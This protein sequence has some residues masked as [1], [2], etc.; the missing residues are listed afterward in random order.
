VRLKIEL[1]SDKTKRLP[2]NYHYQ[3]SSAIYLLLKFSSSEFSDFLHNIGYKL[4]GKPYKLFT[5][6]LK[7]EKYSTSN[8]EIILESPNI[9]LTVSSPKID[10][11]IK[12]FVIGSFERTFFYI[13][14]GGDEH[15][16][17]IK[18]MEL[19][20]EPDFSDAM[21]FV[22]HSPMVISTPKEYNG[23]LSPYYLRPE[24]IEEINRILSINLCNKYRLINNQNIDGSVRLTWD[25]NYLNRHPRITKKITINE[26]GKYPV[27]IIGIQAPFK[28][29]GSKELI[30]VGYDCG[31]GEKNSMGFGMAEVVNG[32]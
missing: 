31:F 1:H 12:N 27:D 29:E 24:E 26:H 2:F 10:E 6:S 25:E 18:N 5:F 28:I 23:K 20:P 21:N 11:F 22:L 17:L 15:K 8:S 16:F 3:F 14:F 30:K 9:F 32:H 4:N 7:F 19:I 13:S